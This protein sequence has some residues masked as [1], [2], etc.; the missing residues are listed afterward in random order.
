MKRFGIYE[1]EKI[2]LSVF[3]GKQSVSNNGV[4]TIAHFHKDL[5]KR[6]KKQQQQKINNK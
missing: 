6:F 2:S 1:I 4:D 3:D 5:K